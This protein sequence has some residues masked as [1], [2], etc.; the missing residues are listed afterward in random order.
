MKLAQKYKEEDFSLPSQSVCR[1]CGTS[2]S[3]QL[4]ICLEA[5]LAH[6][7]PDWRADFKTNSREKYTA[8]PT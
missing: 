2:I 3:A 5:L 1:M 7:V 6:F 8:L 4:L